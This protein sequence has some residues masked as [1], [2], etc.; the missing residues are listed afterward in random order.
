[1]MP[2]NINRPSKNRYVNSNVHNRNA[3]ALRRQNF[4]LEM[5]RRDVDGEAFGEFTCSWTV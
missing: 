1:M 5:G 4:V 3:L 2:G